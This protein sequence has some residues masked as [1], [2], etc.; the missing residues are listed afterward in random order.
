MIKS[1]QSPWR[2]IVPAQF[3]S[4]RVLLSR[5]AELTTDIVLGSGLN[6]TASQLARGNDV[7]EELFTANRSA[8]LTAR[9]TYAVSYR[10]ANFIADVARTSVGPSDHF[11]HMIAAYPDDF[12]RNDLGSDKPLWTGDKQTGKTLLVHAV[13]L[14]GLGD[15]FQFAPLVNEAKAQGGF[16]KVI[17]EVPK[18]MVPLFEGKGLAD[19]VHAKGDPLP[20]H[21]AV[22]P[23]MSLPSVLGVNLQNFYAREA[24]LAPTWKIATPENDWIN[25]N[26]RN[27]QVRGE[28]VVGLAWQGDAGNFSLEPHRSMNLAQLHPLLDRLDNTQFICL[29]NPMDVPKSPLAEQFAA[30]SDRQRSKLTILPA[31]FD[32]AVMFADTMHAMKAMDMVVSTDTGTAHAAGAAGARLVVLGQNGCEMRYPTAAMASLTGD[33]GG[34]RCH[35]QPLEYYAQ[36]SLLQQRTAGD[37]NSVTD[38]LLSELSFREVRYSNASAD[39][40]PVRRVARMLTEM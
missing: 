20:A 4:P 24:Y 29:Q 38:A 30:L 9:D 27:R 34:Q 16:D 22:L 18:R 14:Q 8:D 2:S 5:I 36:A 25:A 37:W 19:I 10:A 1:Q 39:K 23:M 12:G 26:I 15:V 21:D 35:V 33:F 7:A 31:E 3:V 13:K 40:L 32:K 28:L 6:L 17:F 11:V